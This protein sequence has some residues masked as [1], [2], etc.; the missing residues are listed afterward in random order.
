MRSL[1]NFAFTRTEIS[2]FI[3]GQTLCIPGSSSYH[4]SFEFLYLKMTLES[5]LMD[6]VAIKQLVEAYSNV[7][8]HWWLYIPLQEMAAMIEGVREFSESRLESFVKKK[9][10]EK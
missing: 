3:Q 4:S 8:G 7:Q 9:V 2:I 5:G 6:D 1:Q 10:D